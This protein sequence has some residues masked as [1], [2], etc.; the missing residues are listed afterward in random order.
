MKSFA[1]ILDRVGPA[2][3]AK[4]R[5]RHGQGTAKALGE[6]LLPATIMATIP[7]QAGHATNRM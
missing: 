6:A 2:R 1:I 4:A 3:S 7:L 5:P